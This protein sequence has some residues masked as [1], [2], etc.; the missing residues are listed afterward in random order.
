MTPVELAGLAAAGF[1][2]ATMNAIAGGGSFVSFPALIFAGVPGVAANASS[3]VAL[4]PGTLASSWAYRKV[5]GGFGGVPLPLLLAIS[6]AGG[7]CGAL[8]L[9]FTPA[10]AFDG[11]VPW[12]LLVASVTFAFGKQAGEALRRRVRLGRGPLMAA[13]FVLGVYGGYF[14]GAVGI[15]MMAAWMLLGQVDLKA[16]NATR[17]LLVSMMNGIAVVC[18]ILAGIVEWPQTLALL[19]GSVAGGYGGARLVRGMDPQKF[20]RLVIVLTFTMTALFFLRR[21]W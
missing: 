2:A 9:L 6:C 17:M 5:I 20:R 16:L 11:L 12:L 18:F 3:T 14:G 15:M 1:V 13:Q 8:L 21:Y 10:V 7:L 4:F 19:C